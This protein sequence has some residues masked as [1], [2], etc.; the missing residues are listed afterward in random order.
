MGDNYEL[1]KVDDVGEFEM[2]H[3]DVRSLTVAFCETALVYSMC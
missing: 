3:A 1:S 2:H